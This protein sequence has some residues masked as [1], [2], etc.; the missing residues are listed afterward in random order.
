MTARLFSAGNM[1]C[2][3]KGENLMENNKDDEFGKY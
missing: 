1:Q 2:H 3:L